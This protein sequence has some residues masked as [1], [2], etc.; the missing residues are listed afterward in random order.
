MLCIRYSSI[1]TIIRLVRH[2]PLGEQP[3]KRLGNVEHA[4]MLERARPVARIEQMQNRM[5]DPADILADREPF[6][7]DRTVEWLVI[8]LAGEAHEIP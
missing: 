7:D 6:L 1:D 2:H 8:G 3:G 5:L 4:D